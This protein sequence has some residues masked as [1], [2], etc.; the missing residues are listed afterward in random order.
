[1]KQILATL[2]F[3]SLV[4]LAVAQTPKLLEVMEE[5]LRREMDVL[6]KAEYPAY[7]IDYRVNEMDHVSITASFGS[8]VHSSQDRNRVLTTTVKVGDYALDNTRQLEEGGYGYHGVGH[9]GYNAILPIEDTPNALKQ[10][11]WRAT[12]AEYKNASEAY[13]SIK[14]RLDQQKTERESADFSREEPTVYVEEPLP[15]I[16]AYLD[17]QAWEQ[18]VKAV[19]TLFQQN[20][21]ITEG[22]VSIAFTREA[23]YFI[24]TE[25]TR[26][27]QYMTYAYMHLSASIIAEDGDVLPL[28]HTYFAFDPKD[29]PTEAVMVEDVKKM[30]TKLELL[31]NAPLAEPYSG[32][33]I[34]DAR[35]AG[36]FFHEIFGHRIEGHRLKSETDAQTFLSRVNDQVLS[37]NI[38]VI[39]DP[40]ITRYGSQ[41]LIGTY[42]YDDQGVKGQ[43]V[44][45]ID[46]GVLRRFLM[47]RSPLQEFAKSN[48]HGRASAG[49]KAVSRQSNL[50]IESEKPKKMQALRSMLVKECKKQGKPYGYLFSDVTGGFTNTDRYSANVFNIM[51]IEVYRIYTDGRPDELV[52]GVDLIGTPLAMFAEI[53]ATGNTKEVF[54]GICGAESGGVPVSAIAPALFVRRIETQKKVKGNM[55]PA[56]LSR[57]GAT[58]A[59][60]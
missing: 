1:V 29:L 25:G 60:N 2:F 30:I 49:M 21:N 24:S 42:K 48:G 12:T 38:S 17:K 5:E 39:S 54:T 7:Y 46:R 56:L 32:P 41:D 35:T 4:Q 36:V 55:K 11:L 52:R 13:K 31:R 3:T 19:S 47:S 18:R 51:P 58:P 59:S 28:Y 53:E 37:K 50:I 33:A 6:Q 34:L 57:P 26:V 22:D 10:A 16:E 20:V 45:V 40:S 8:L 44:Q 23:K 27:V 9:G 43:R 15:A 14:N